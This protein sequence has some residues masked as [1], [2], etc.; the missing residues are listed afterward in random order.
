[1]EGGVA[2]MVAVSDV[3]QIVIGFGSLFVAVITLIIAII[4]LTIKK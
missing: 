3:F 4:A 2:E 1:M